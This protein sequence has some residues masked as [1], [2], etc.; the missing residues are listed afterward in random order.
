ML[1]YF[2]FFIFFFLTFFSE[3]QLEGIREDLGLSQV[4]AFAPGTRLNLWSQ[5]KAFIMFCLYFNFDWLPASQQVIALFAQFLSRSLRS[6]ASVRNYISGV[7]LLH[8]LLDQPC[9]VFDDVKLSL[10]I[11]GMIRNKA[12][13]TRQALPITIDILCKIYSYLDMSMPNHVVFW[14]LFTMAFFTM[15]RKSNLVVTSLKPPFKCIRRQDVLWGNDCLIVTF[16][17]SK[18][19]QYGNRVHSVPLVSMRGSPLCPVQAYR[20][21]C[22]IF[23]VK[24][25]APAFCMI[26]SKGVLPVTYYDLQCFLREILHVLGYNS[27][28]YSSHSFRR[29][30]AS[31]AFKSGV[32]ARLIQAW[33]DWSSDAYKEYIHL[34]VS[35]KVSAIKL[36]YAKC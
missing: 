35:D 29:G 8:V 24:P 12:H 5:W 23:Q 6:I 1:C 25:D 32:P 2:L 7:K 21:M 30:A 16:R 3:I 15:A 33:G 22:S 27:H 34:D 9:R 31:L 18:T 19:N 4:S 36:M 26:K 17:W 28:L 13:I 11:R 10:A 14:S 20:N